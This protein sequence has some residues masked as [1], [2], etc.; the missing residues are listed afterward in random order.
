[1]V[2]HHADVVVDARAVGT[3]P[4]DGAHAVTP[5]EMGRAGTERQDNCSS[6]CWQGTPAPGPKL[7]P[8]TPPR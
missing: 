7:G 2:V 5:L 6:G 3:L 1:M 8:V 4:I